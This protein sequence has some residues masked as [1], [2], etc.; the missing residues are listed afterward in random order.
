MGRLAVG[1]FLLALPSL[2]SAQSA[3]ETVAYIVG[4][5]EVTANNKLIRSSPAEYEMTVQTPDVQFV[6]HT[7]ISAIDACH[8]RFVQTSDAMAKGKRILIVKSS[9]Y[10]FS[11]ASPASKID[12]VKVADAS[13]KK[14]V[15]PGL[16]AA[17]CSLRIQQPENPPSPHES[18]HFQMA[19]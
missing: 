4:G 6:T 11:G 9:D 18:P 7:I 5:I 2:A 10:D 14:I 8:Y 19:P 13:E 12:E 1:F 3:E 15:I 16:K 17:N